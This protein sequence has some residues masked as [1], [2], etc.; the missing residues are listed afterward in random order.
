MSGVQSLPKKGEGVLHCNR[1]KGR[2]LETRVSG[3]CE[4]LES[5]LYRNVINGG[6]GVEDGRGQADEEG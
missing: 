2:S 3:T 6:D 5:S 4:S 1:R